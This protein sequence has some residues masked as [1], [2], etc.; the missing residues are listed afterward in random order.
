M[1]S[2]LT[3]R[4]SPVEEHAA[5]S[6]TGDVSTGIRAGDGR[7]G[8][9]QPGRTLDREAAPDAAAAA[10][11]W[12]SY[13]EAASAMPSPSRAPTCQAAAQCANQRA[14]PSGSPVANAAAD[15][16]YSSAAR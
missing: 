4:R 6:G 7:V 16:R 12:A 8:W 15:A 11:G 5:A 1:S 2:P 9:G 10:S 3:A 13:A 14:R